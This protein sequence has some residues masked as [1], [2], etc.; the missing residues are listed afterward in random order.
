[1]A[2]KKGKKHATKTGGHRQLQ[3]GGVAWNTPMALDAATGAGRKRKTAIA[4]NIVDPNDAENMQ[5]RSKRKADYSPIQKFKVKRSALGNLTKNTNNMSLHP[6]LDEQQSKQPSDQQSEQPAKK[7]K[8]MEQDAKLKA[9][10]RK[11]AFV[12]ANK[13]TTGASSKVEH[14]VE[15]S[16]EHGHK[17]GKVD[18]L[19]E[20]Q[21]RP[22]RLPKAVPAAKKSAVGEQLPSMPSIPSMPSNPAVPPNVEDFDRKHWDDPLQVSTYAMDIFE[23]LKGREPVFPIVDYMP[24]QIHLTAGIRAI[25][26]DWM[27]VVQQSFGFNAETMYLAM[28]IVDLYLSRKVIKRDQILLLGVVAYLI[29]CKYDEWQPPPLIRD[30]LYLSNASYNY[31]QVVHMEL[32][33]LRTIE[34]EL[35]VP[36]ACRFLRRYARCAE[37]PVPTLTLANYILEM[38]LMDYATVAFRDSQ[39]AC[40]VL[41]MALRMSGG[42]GQLGPATNTWSP[43][44]VHYSGYQLTE[45]VKI[46][47]VLNAGLHRNQPP[48]IKTIREKYSLEKF[49][50]VAMVPLLTDLQLFQ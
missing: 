12:A 16:V 2:P 36:L 45:F 6:G 21:A 40:A 23:Y 37:V 10:K 48:N 35:G 9:K 25:L 44:L 42:S 32:E 14:S 15:L 11:N 30:F 50:E 3:A 13:G 47:R 38:A 5:R 33:T 46:V 20:A 8:A 19:E 1:M 43:T 34:F 39:M 49:H 4:G 24:R 29:A 22:K 18:K 27:V 26:V 17:V 31:N 28:K 41:F 7:P